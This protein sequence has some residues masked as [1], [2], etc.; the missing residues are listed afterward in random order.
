MIRDLAESKML[1]SVSQDNRTPETKSAATRLVG[2]PR[3][4][5]RAQPLWRGRF[6][7]FIIPPSIIGMG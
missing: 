2:F 7:W 1:S 5:A 6:V 4:M 3:R